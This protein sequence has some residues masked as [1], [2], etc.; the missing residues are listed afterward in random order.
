LDYK[1]IRLERDSAHVARLTLARP[2]IQ[3]ALSLD[4]V[5]ELL[6]THYDPGYR[7]SMVRNFRQ[8][9]GAPELRPRD[10]TQAAMQELAAQMLQA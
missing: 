3:N 1:T 7:Q 4:V 10:R 5:R 6:L 8:F 2:E 9:E